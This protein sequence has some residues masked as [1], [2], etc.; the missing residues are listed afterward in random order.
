MKKLLAAAVALSALAACNQQQATETEAA[1]AVQLYAM[2]CGRA[3]FPNVDMFADDGSFAGQ[4]RELIVPCYLIRHPEGDLIWDTGFPD[5]VAAM[6][7][8]R[9]E[10]PEM[11]ATVVMRASLQSQLAQLDLTPADIEF[12]SFSHQHGDHTGNGNLFAG[13]T[14]LVDPEERAYMFSEEA[15]GGQ[16]FAGYSQLENAQTRL[17]E[18]DA[19][20]VFGDGSV[21][22]FQAP[23]HTPGHTVL[24]VQLPNAGAVLLTGDM[25]HLAESRER[26]TVPRFNTDREQ[27]LQSMDRV[28]EIG[29]AANARVIRQHVIEDFDSLPRFPEALN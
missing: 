14:W 27:T 26:R 13:S 8:G 10:L 2:D 6:P 28:E 3:T 11:G 21:K 1:P 17:I 25:Y 4:S 24:L 22:I 9:R 18:S 5:A 19:Y 12:V 16:A 23:G 29:H 7:G 20:D 15:R